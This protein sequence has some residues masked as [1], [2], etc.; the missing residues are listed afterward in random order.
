MSSRTTKNPQ[1]ISPK[2][3]R[4]SIGW[5]GVL[6]P[7]ALILGNSVLRHCDSLQNSISHYFY[8]V[9]GSWLVG[10]LCAVAMFL[11]SY[12]GYD[13]RDNITSSIAG[14]SAVLIA[15]FPTNMAKNVPVEIERNEC[16][17]FSL[18]ENAIRNVVHYVSAGIFFLSLAYMSYFLFTKTGSEP[19][20]KNKMIRNR[21][22]TTCGIV[23]LAAILLIAIYGIFGDQLSSID[24]YKP[25]FWLEWI[26]LMAFGLSWLIKGE[27][28]LKED[29]IE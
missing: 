15:F 14:F 16:L 20:T 18:K 13:K 4:Q 3:L 22:F 29:K 28:I 10:M 12:K 19:M 11:I 25:V 2:A 5:M 6:L 7:A 8:T 23:I 17:L 21:T 9:T 1:L 27:I 26:A 24:K